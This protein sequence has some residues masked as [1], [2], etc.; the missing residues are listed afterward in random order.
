M[1]TD[2]VLVEVVRGVGKDPRLAAWIEALSDE[3]LAILGLS[4]VEVTA[5]R[6]GFLDRAMR[7]GI[8][9]EPDAVVFGCCAS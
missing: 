7:L 3:E 2:T 1:T 8:V 5:I 9:P 4:P 6:G